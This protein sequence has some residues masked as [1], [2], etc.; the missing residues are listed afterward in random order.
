MPLHEFFRL[1]LIGLPTGID[2]QGQDH[3]GEI[4]KQIAP[5]LTRQYS[6]VFGD[7]FSLFNDELSGQNLAIVE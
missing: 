6:L 3:L 4:G 1:G 2:D 5:L 7:F